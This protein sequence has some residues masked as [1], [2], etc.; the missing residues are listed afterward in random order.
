MAKNVTIH[1]RVNKIKF[2]KKSFLS[3]YHETKLVRSGYAHTQSEA[4]QRRETNM[5]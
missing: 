3:F 4:A 1:V 2:K 5:T